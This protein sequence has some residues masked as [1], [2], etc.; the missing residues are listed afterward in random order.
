MQF[1]PIEVAEARL[2]E[3][4]GIGSGAI[5]QAASVEPPIHIELRRGNAQL[6]VRWPSSQA[7]ACAAWLSELAN[8]ALK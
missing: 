8:T 2:I 3:P 4:R 6:T 5:P 1:V 7:Q